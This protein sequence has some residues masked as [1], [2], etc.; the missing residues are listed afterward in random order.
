MT[1]D[2]ERQARLI[3][4]ARPGS[5]WRSPPSWRPRSRSARRP[6][7]STSSSASR[8]PATRSSGSSSSPTRRRTR[9]SGARTSRSSTTA[10]AAPSTS[11]ARASAAARPCRARRPAPTRG[12]SSRSRASRRTRASKTM[13]AG[14]AFSKDFREERGHAY[15]LDDQTYTE[16]QQ[17]VKQPGTCIHCHGSVYVPYRKLGGGDLIKGFEMMNQMPFTEAR[18]LVEHPVA[19]I[20]CHDPA[21]HAAARDA[22]G[23]PRGHQAR[24]GQG[25]H[26][27]LRRQHDGD[28]SGDAH[29]RVRAVPRRVLLQGP[30][31]AAH[32]PLART[33]IKGDE[34]LAYYEKE[35]FSDWTHAE[36]G[37]KTLKAQHPEFEMYNQGIHARSGVACA[38]C[39][40]PY[41]REGGQKVTRPPRAQPAAQRQ[42]G[43]P[44]VPQVV[45]GRTEGARR[46]HPGARVRAAQPRHGRAD[47]AHRRHEGRA[48]QGRHRRAARRRR[49]GSSGPRSSCW[50][51]SRPR[52]RSASTRRP[53]P[54]ACWPSRST[55][56]VRG[57][58]PCCVRGAPAPPTPQMPT[59]A[60]SVAGRPSPKDAV[61][62][63]A[64]GASERRPYRRSRLSRRSTCST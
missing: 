14:Y 33:G 42:P 38:D 15:M 52:T 47:V 64:Q 31:E 56:R 32:L 11:S 17:V 3:P 46:D 13:W 6:C 39:H 49:G 58:S 45:G 60:S 12:R 4:A 53:K 9:P 23:L 16:R 30:G 26:R 19:C 5:C 59:A 21:T 40:M 27:E 36:T 44:D 41:Q 1:T 62:G 35:G 29:V 61:S 51:S 20:D 7:W 24:Q 55:S 54:S 18:K 28:A 50:I 34:I 2:E 10:T 25:R 63:T 57:R 8:K 22:A 43:L 48:R 37:A